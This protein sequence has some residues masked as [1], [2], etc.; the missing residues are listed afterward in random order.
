MLLL[1]GW[2][3]E[4]EAA[5]DC[6]ALSSSARSIR[7]FKEPRT[8]KLH[9]AERRIIIRKRSMLGMLGPRLL[10]DRWLET[11]EMATVKVRVVKLKVGEGDDGFAAE[12][13]DDN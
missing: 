9:W 10:N 1:E 2:F 4:E 8:A 11:R 5:A 3:E 13:G 12:N 7:L 6:S